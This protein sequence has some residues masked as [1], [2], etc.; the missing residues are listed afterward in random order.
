MINMILMIMIYKIN[1]LFYLS[2]NGIVEMFVVLFLI[3]LCMLNDNVCRIEYDEIEMFCFN[4][5]LC[6]VDIVCEE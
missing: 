4:D 5:L 2:W 1:D 3:V 6:C